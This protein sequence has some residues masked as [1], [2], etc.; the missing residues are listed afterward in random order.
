MILLPFS[1]YG[2]HLE[3]RVLL[4]YSSIAIQLPK[5]L[6]NEWIWKGQPSEINFTRNGQQALRVGLHRK[7]PSWWN[8]ICRHSVGDT[9]LVLL[10]TTLLFWL[11]YGQL[12]TRSM[13]EAPSTLKTCCSMRLSCLQMT[14]EMSVRCEVSRRTLDPWFVLLSIVEVCPLLCG[15]LWVL[16]NSV[17]FFCGLCHPEHNYLRPIFCRISGDWR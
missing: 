13:W 9:V 2:I 11:L 5:L 4:Q 6:R 17:I 15:A 1:S 12:A 7:F 3:D 14:M 10:T 8:S 16:R